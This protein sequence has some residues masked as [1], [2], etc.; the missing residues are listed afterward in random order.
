VFEISVEG[1]PVDDD[2][3]FFYARNDQLEMNLR[4]VFKWLLSI[5]RFSDNTNNVSRET[6]IPIV[7]TDYRMSNREQIVSALLRFNS[8]PGVELS[9]NVEEEAVVPVMIEQNLLEMGDKRRL[10]CLITVASYISERR[11]K[12]KLMSLIKKQLFRI[13]NSGTGDR[14][15]RE[16]CRTI[17]NQASKSGMGELRTVNSAKISTTKI[18][19][20]RAVLVAPS[21]ST[22]GY[23]GGSL[24]LSIE[25]TN[26]TLL[27]TCSGDRL[28]Q[29]LK[30]AARALE[31]DIHSVFNRL[32]A[33]ESVNGKVQQTK[34]YSVCYIREEEVITVR[35]GD[36]TPNNLNYRLVSDS[37]LSPS[38]LF[39]TSL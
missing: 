22:G 14:G 1:V 10:K 20:G 29:Y 34:G 3:Q 15:F 26:Q 13:S 25:D 9:I 27:T 28:S 18:K 24:Q 36:S 33:P 31:T 19:N 8:V 35:P 38:L 5:I 2:N 6:V 16:R 30:A 4:S 21:M 23:S 17:W 7:Y 32:Q 39:G 11:T 37:L 12:E